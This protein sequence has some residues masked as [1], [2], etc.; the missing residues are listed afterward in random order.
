MSNWVT[1][2]IEAAWEYLRYTGADEITVRSKDKPAS[3]DGSYVRICT[4]ALT[5]HDE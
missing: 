3:E 1:N 4:V 5:I 2:S